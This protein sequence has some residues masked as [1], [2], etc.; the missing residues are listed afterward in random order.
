MNGSTELGAVAPFAYNDNGYG[1][2]VVALYFDASSAPAWGQNYTVILGNNPLLSSWNGSSV[3][4][5]FSGFNEWNDNVISTTRNLV[6]L[7]ILTMAQELKV[8]WGVD[9][10]ETAAGGSYLTT[11][12]E[13]YFMSTVPY[14]MEIA[15]YAFSTSVGQPNY[16]DI[17]KNYTY[18]QNLEDMSK[19]TIADV[20]TPTASILGTTRGEATAVIYYAA[21]IIMLILICR[22]MNTYKPLMLLMA[23]FVALGWA[24]G[25]PLD[26][27]VYAGLIATFLLLFELLY[28]PTLS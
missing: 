13:D 4:T 26:I 25:V 22:A 21:V 3:S 5:S 10:M 11:Y 12:G 9:L 8:A 14:L 17:T 23:P 18:A 1:E 16:P 24:V 20:G 6:S 2:G 7:R 15:P 19:N 27:T 28:K